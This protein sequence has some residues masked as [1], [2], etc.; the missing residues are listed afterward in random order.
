MLIGACNPVLKKQF[1]KKSRFTSPGPFLDLVE[2]V[3]ARCGAEKPLV[4]HCS[5]GI[6][7]SGVFTIMSVVRQKLLDPTFL[8]DLRAKGEGTLSHEA[9]SLKDLTTL[10]RMARFRAVAQ[11]QV[12][13]DINCPRL[14]FS[15]RQGA[16]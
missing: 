1:I 5:A 12:R 9:L 6:G 8:N 16:Y 7:R 4:A 14:S 3:D 13:Q 10:A 11:T 2:E 15:P